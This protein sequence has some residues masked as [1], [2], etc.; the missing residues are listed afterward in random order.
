MA[1]HIKNQALERIVAQAYRDHPIETCGIVVSAS[2]STVASRVVPM[3]NQAA[4]ETFFL[5]DSREQFRVFRELDEHGETCRV[6]YHSH[7]VSEA[8]PSREDIEYAGS[9]E[10]HYL[11][12]STWDHAREAIRSFRLLDGRAIEES[13]CILA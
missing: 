10:A 1:L 4:S 12:V 6:I 11:I 9:P 7:T 8:Y 2:G 13:V 3:R 5:F